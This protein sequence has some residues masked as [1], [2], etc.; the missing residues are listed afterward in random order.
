M[1]IRKEKDGNKFIMYV[2]GAIDTTTSPSLEIE[3]LEA[4]KK[5][6][7]IEELI[8]DLSN[9]NY[10]SSAG[11]RVFLKTHKQLDSMGG[12]FIIKHPRE[13]VMEVFDMTGFS[14]FLTIEE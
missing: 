13:E 5:V 12:K 8:I 6:K 7:G 3:V 9:T 11:L 14:T 4:I 1:E 2:Q 10:V